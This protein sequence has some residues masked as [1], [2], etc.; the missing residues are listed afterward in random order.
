MGID[1]YSILLWAHVLLLVFWLGADVGVLVA[2]SWFKNRAYSVS[3]RGLL[4]K[5]AATIDLLPR[6]CFALALPVGFTLASARWNLPFPSSLLGPVWLL[7]LVWIAIILVAFRLHDKP[8][9]KQLARLQFGFLVIAG[10]GLLAYGASLLAAGSPVQPWLAW[11]IILYGVIFFLAIG[12]DMAFRPIL[13]AFMRLASEG[14][15]DAVE[16]D[17]SRAMNNTIAVVLTLYA[18]LLA[19]SFLGVTKPIL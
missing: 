11:K 10:L 14:S 2:G 19:I 12:I 5:L 13:P 9:A 4:L 7:D 16:S 1:G 17:I 6:I 15:S 3:E 8:I 18:M